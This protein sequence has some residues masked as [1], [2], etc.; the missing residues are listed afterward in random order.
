MITVV[1]QFITDQNGKRISVILSLKDFNTLMEKLEV[2]EDIQLYDEAKK[3]NELSVPIDD[4]FKTLTENVQPATLN[5][6]QQYKG[7]MSK[8]SLND[9]DKQL[10]ELRNGWE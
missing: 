3:S 9:I 5:W 8:Q 7:A 1:P 6:A 2:L 4:A 10:N